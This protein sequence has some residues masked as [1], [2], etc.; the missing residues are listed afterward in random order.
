MY[1]SWL[2][3]S[4]IVL[5][6]S[7]V[8]LGAPRCDAGV[9]FKDTFN[10]EESRNVDGSL[11][12]ITD[13]T[14]SSLAVDGVYTHP[15]LDPANDPGPQDGDPSNGGGAQILN[16]ELRLAVG[17][18]TSNAYVNHNFI[19]NEILTAGG[20][21]VSV[22]V[23]G[24]NQNGR[25]QGGGFALGMS[26]AE[27]D[28][29]GD[30]FNTS[31][32]SLTGAYHGDPYGITGQPVA[33]GNIVSDFWIG[34]RGN[35]SLAWGS[36]TGNVLGVPVNG[37]PVKTGNITVNFQA[38]DFNA[39]STVGYSVFYDGAL[40]GTGSFTW[41]GTNENYISLDGRDNQFVSFDNFTVTTLPEPSSAALALLGLA[42]CLVRRRAA[43]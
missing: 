36:S 9:L 42:S 29:A 5:A 26:Q 8:A 13:N 33:P 20:F 7:M 2:I 21:R 4:A 23:T 35:N 27:A 38:S 22:D 32:P 39:G 16:Q 41:S 30:A 40:Q 14:G 10:R 37:L 34:I 15:H 3:S 17:A 25:Q 24:Y 28:S 12:G 43:R 1:R 6:A 31:D 18:G 11:A 19:N